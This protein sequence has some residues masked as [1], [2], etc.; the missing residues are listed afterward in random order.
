MIHR[1]VLTGNYFFGGVALPVK[2]ALRGVRHVLLSVRGAALRSGDRLP[3]PL[4]AFG[5]EAAGRLDR[6]AARVDRNSSLVAHRYLDPAISR[7][8]ETAAFSRLVQHGD[9]A[10]LFAKVAYDNLK[11]TVPYMCRNAERQESFFISEMLA[12]MA[13]RKAARRFAGRDDDI[14][15]AALLLAAML[16]TGVVR[17][18]AS[19]NAAQSSEQAVRRLARMATF[20]TV[21]WLVVA[22]DCTPQGEEKLLFAC[23]DLAIVLAPEI[24]AAGD[25]GG[26]LAALLKTHAGMV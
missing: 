22:R 11:L 5:G 26:Q 19:A 24:D 10:V 15:K 23:C 21:L 1:P 17:T 16:R 9:A 14:E 12:A 2:E 8:A 25:D 18:A 20:A 4:R 7:D 13:Y 6:L 3:R